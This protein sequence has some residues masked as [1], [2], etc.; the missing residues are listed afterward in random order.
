MLLFCNQ[1]RIM[2]D[3]AVNLHFELA[4]YRGP[5]RR[6]VRIAPFMIGGPSIVGKGGI[7]RYE[8]GQAFASLHG[9]RLAV[10]DEEHLGP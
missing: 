5:F 2:T 8:V 1:L 3:S 6:G 10:G 4:A 9:A 7:S